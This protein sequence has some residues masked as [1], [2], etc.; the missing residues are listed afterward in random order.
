MFAVEIVNEYVLFRKNLF[1]G[2]MI[3]KHLI[4]LNNAISGSSMK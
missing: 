2:N 3:F 1:M 4:K